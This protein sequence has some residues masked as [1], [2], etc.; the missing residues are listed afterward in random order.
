MNK[1]PEY[2]L[3]AI[4]KYQHS[5]KGKRKKEIW[6]KKN[7]EKLSKYYKEYNENYRN[8]LKRNGS[9]LRCLKPNFQFK[10]HVHCFECRTLLTKK[11]NEKRHNK[12]NTL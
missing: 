11:Q 12:H 9:C 6:K 10:T 5:A 4:R 8:K 3:R 1:T 2:T 7:K